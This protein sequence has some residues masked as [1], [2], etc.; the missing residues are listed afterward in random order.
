MIS[1]SGIG[2]LNILKGKTSIPHGMGKMTL[3]S[4]EG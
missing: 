2:Y 4:N 3:H 1:Y